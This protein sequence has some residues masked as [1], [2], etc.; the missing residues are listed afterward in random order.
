[1]NWLRENKLVSDKVRQ[2]MEREELRREPSCAIM[3]AGRDR[4]PRW[5]TLE[6]ELVSLK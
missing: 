3:E 5:D 2:V 6:E 1:M 4:S